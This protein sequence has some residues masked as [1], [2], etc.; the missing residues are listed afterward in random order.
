MDQLHLVV[1]HRVDARL[2]LEDVEAHRLGER[3]A[4]SD[5]D[6]VSLLH[7][8]PAGRAVHRHVLVALLEPWFKNTHK[9]HTPTNR[10]EGKKQRQRIE[11]RFFRER[12]TSSKN[13]WAS[14]RKG[15]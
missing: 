10:V 14:Q 5:R 6:D 2:V 4:L 13:V 8:L 3:P 15:R 12:G 1:P 11:R 9:A 7:V